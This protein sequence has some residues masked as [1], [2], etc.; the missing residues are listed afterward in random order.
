MHLVTVTCNRDFSQM[1]LQAESIS[2]FLES[3]THYIIINEKDTDLAFWWRWLSPYYTNHKLVLLK[4]ISYEYNKL[5]YPDVNTSV[6]TGWA[7]QQLQKLLIAYHLNDDYLLLDSKNFFIK[8]TSL[9]EWDNCIGENFLLKHDPQH[10]YCKVSE[11][12]AKTLGMPIKE[13][14]FYPR[15]PFKIKKNLITESKLFDFYSIGKTICEPMSALRLP[16]SEFV[17]YSYLIDQQEWEKIPNSIYPEDVIYWNFKEDELNKIAE[18]FDKNNNVKIVAFHRG[19]LSEV[20]E[21]ALNLI[22]ALLKTLGFTNKISPLP[23]DWE[24]TPG[25]NSESNFK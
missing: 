23:P 22:N 21:K 7:I 2:K 1:L 24:M 11:I 17:F 3:C 9:N 5:P 25:L 10:I 12:Y 15:T 13:Q 4:R 14:V 20:D 16:I 18:S 8:H 6:A 19:F